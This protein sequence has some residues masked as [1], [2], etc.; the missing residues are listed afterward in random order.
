MYVYR[1]VLAERHKV[2]PDTISRIVREMVKSG[3]Y[4]K[5]VKKCGRLEISEEDF[6]DYLCK[7]GGRR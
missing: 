1:E 4:P 7:R 2:V 5:A 3:D 6:E